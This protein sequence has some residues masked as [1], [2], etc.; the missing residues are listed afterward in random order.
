M[1]A[2]RSILKPADNTGAKRLRV[3][4]VYVGSRRRYGRLGDT[5]L[6][7]VI[8]AAPGGTVKKK[9]KVKVVIVRT[10]KENRRKDGSYIRFSDNAAVIIDNNNN[11]RGTRIFGPIAREIKEKGF[12]KIA[13]MAKEVV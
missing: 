13:S 5:A 1:I 6:A 8:E 7:S 11:P 10:R 4:H 2:L 9:E 12:T 3:I